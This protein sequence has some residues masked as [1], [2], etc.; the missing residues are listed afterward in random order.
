MTLSHIA[1]EI[2]G[3]NQVFIKYPTDEVISGVT[4]INE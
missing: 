4:P 2:I 3:K 1:K